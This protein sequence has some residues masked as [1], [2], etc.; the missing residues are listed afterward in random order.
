M[1]Y[2]LILSVVAAGVVT[3][4]RG[5]KETTEVTPVEKSLSAEAQAGE[6]LYMENC[7]RCHDLPKIPD[8]SAERWERIVPSMSKKAH[9]DAT[10]E[11]SVMT[12][13]R[14]MQK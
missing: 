1:K 12:Y 7:G 13:V 14:E 8:Y 6:K 4:C 5:P 2:F 3:A 10:Q 11:Q 9:L